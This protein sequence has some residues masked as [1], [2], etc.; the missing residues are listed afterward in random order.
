MSLDLNG[1]VSEKE[2]ARA[3]GTE[4]V[5]YHQRLY[6]H[7]ST[8]REKGTRPKK[9]PD[10]YDREVQEQAN[11]LQS[12]NNI[13]EYLVQNSPDIQPDIEH[14]RAAINARLDEQQLEVMAGKA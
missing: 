5:L 10:E 12:L 1:E 13:T 3:R 2:V 7:V 11:V 4:A 8:M 9:T 14:V 6:K